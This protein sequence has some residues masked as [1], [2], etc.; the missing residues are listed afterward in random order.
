MTDPVD[1]TWW[2]A[3]GSKSETDDILGQTPLCLA[4]SSFAAVP[5]A[6]DQA[7]EGEKW[8]G[9]QCYYMPVEDKGNTKAPQFDDMFQ[10]DDDLL[11]ANMQCVPERK[12]SVSQRLPTAISNLCAETATADGKALN[13]CYGFISDTIPLPVRRY[14]V[15]PETSIEPTTDSQAAISLQD[16]LDG[17]DA[18]PVMTYRDKLCLAVTIASGVLQLYGTPWLSQSFCS[19]NIIFLRRSN[20]HRPYDTVFL[21][22]NV[23][24]EPLSLGDPT[25]PLAARRNPALLS[26]GFLLV[27]IFIGRPLAR[28]GGPAAERLAR[29]FKEAQALLPRIRVESSNY[30]SA[31]SRCLDGKLHTSQYDEVKL[32]ERSYTGVVV[33]LKK[34]L[35]AVSFAD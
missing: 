22:K 5:Q 15:Y 1:L 21:W 9:L 31:V 4:L 11:F 17:G 27:D 28:D 3:T 32:T 14:F 6:I 13:E 18:V 30:F 2:S 8:R 23:E 29:K 34:D 24:E 16:V 12:R 25:S 20:D 7:A 19:S 10:S 35:E 33:L 26:L